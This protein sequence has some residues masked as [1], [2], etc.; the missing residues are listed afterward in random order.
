MNG[1]RAAIGSC[2]NLEA[3]CTFEQILVYCTVE[4]L[5]SKL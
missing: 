5:S 2:R 3:F 4:T 1:K